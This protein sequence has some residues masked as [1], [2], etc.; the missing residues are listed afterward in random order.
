M[1]LLATNKTIAR[2]RR[3]EPPPAGPRR[4][5]VLLVNVGTPDSPDPGSVRRYLT[6]FLSDP[7]VIDLPA[8]L[9]WLQG[10]LGRAI[11][12][13]RASRSAEKYRQIWTDR[14]SPLKAIMQDQASA[15]EQ[16]LPEGWRV[17]LGM[18]YGRPAIAEALRDIAAGGIEELVVVPMYPQF[19]R[20]TTGSVVQE[21]YRTLRQVG[22]HFNVATRASWYDDSGYVNAQARLIAEYARAHELTPQDTYLLFSAHGLPV[23]YIRQGD[24]YERHVGRTV[25]LVAERLGWPAD[26][27]SLAYQGRFGPTEWLKPDMERRLAEL[28]QAGEKK[29]LVCP[30]SFTVDCLE[31]LEEIGLRRRRHFEARGG[32]L[33][34]CPALNTY[35]PFIAALK[36]LVLRGPQPGAFRRKGAKPLFAAPHK[37]EPTG[38]GLDSLVMLGLSLPSWVGPG[39]GPQ[40]LYS[41]P[42]ELCR[43]RK[44]HEQVGALLQKLRRTGGAREALIWN[45]CHRFEFYGWLDRREAATN[46]DCAVARIRR[47]LFGR[48]PAGLGVNVLFGVEAWHHLM[49]T[50]AGLNSG[51][52]GDRDVVEQLQ[53]AYRLAQRCGAAGPRSKRLVDEAVALA[54][55]VRAETAWGRLSPGYCFAALS[56]VCQAEGLDWAACRHVVIGGSTTSCSVLHTLAERFDACQ[57]QMTLVYRGHRGGQM[58]LLRGA[59]G[60]GKRLRAQSY[61]EPAVVRAIAEADVVF[62]GID[63]DRPVLEAEDLRGVRDFTKRPLTVVDFNTFGST[64]GLETLG[65]VRV[66]DAKRLEEEVAAYAEVMCAEQGF[67]GAAEETEAWIERRSPKSA[68]V[69]LNLPCA[70]AGEVAPPRC[71]RCG[72]VARITAGSRGP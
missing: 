6:Q 47:E 58:K 66:C 40:L 22:P 21:L 1:S 60:N 54:G 59:I 32:Q 67:S 13:S 51:L 42:D 11:A 70:Q 20:T 14:G 50:V 3:R 38:G 39:R 43:F 52:P 16:A 24:P 10:P 15:L 36:A 46:G 31:T 17:F 27:T 72:K 68:P 49:R 23:S 34:L 12:W 55:N 71:T 61:S 45:T 48:E 19:S 9:R 5:G 4:R 33:Y 7:L 57:R 53:T 35:E 44:P 65:G 64:E 37:L 69:N 30:I 28:S 26:R 41:G 8:G 56:R 62:F 25:G 63:R 2:T 18:R 29:V